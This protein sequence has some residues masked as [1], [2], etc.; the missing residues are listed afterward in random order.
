[1]KYRKPRRAM[2]G[3]SRYVIYDS[4]YRPVAIVH[5]ATGELTWCTG[6]GDGGW[7]PK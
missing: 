1:M 4:M 7:R 5:T 3:R 6:D 2:I